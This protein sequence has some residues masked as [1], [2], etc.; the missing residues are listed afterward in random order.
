M[1]GY[2]CPECGDGMVEDTIFHN[3]HTQARGML[4]TVPEAHI[5]VC[6][7]KD[8]A[9]FCYDAKETKRWERESLG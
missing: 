9:A 1:F 5:G 2:R 6:N 8:C 4:I 7:N 3:Y